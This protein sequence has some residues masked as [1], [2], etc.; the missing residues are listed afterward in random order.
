MLAAARRRAAPTEMP[1]T[2][3]RMDRPKRSPTARQP[4]GTRS[5]PRLGLAAVA[6]GV[7]A[8]CVLGPSPTATPTTASTALPSPPST[9]QPTGTP[10]ETGTGQPTATPEPP[11]SLELPSDRDRR[12]VRV[13]VASEVPGDGDGRL[14]VT[15]TNLTDRRVPE[16]VL[17]WPTQLREMLFLAPFEPSQQ[18]R[19]EGG[20]PLWQEWTKWVD[21]PGENGEPAGTT[22]LGWGP[23]LPNATLTIPIV[24]NR[25]ARG[26]VAFDLQVLVEEALLA[27]PNGD[28]AELRVQV[29]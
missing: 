25:Q 20:P 22:S 23:L 8:G 4:R 19:A 2:P 12:R 16:L 28:P 29:P 10:V 1:H 5:L 6:A 9:E 18:R 11:L 27:L 3:G 21:G 17:R 13:N 14:L 15:V 7:L 24:V 26:E